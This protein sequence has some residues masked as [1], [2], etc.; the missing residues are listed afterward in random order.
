MSEIIIYNRIE[1]SILKS[2]YI[3]FGIFILA[4]CTDELSNQEQSNGET[5]APQG[6]V[7]I[8]VNFRTGSFHLPL[9]KS[10]ENLF[11]APWV[12]SFKLGNVD[13]ATPD[14]LFEEAVVLKQINKSYMMQLT[15]S[16]DAHLL[17]FVANASDLINK[18][19]ASFIG[20]KYW[21]VAS[22]LSFGDPSVGE[23]ENPLKNPQTTI[24]FISEPIPMTAFQQ[25]PKI[26]KGVTLSSPINLQRIV[27]KIYVDA[28]Q[29]NVASNFNLT[30]VTVVGVPAL[31]YLDNTISKE[32]VAPQS[33]VD[34]GTESIGTSIITG[35]ILNNIVAN[36][37]KSDSQDR[38]IYVYPFIK[39]ADN[40]GQF[41]VLL[42]GNFGGETKYFKIRLGGI[43]S[44][45]QLI[46]PNTSFIINIE[47][48][49][50]NGYVAIEHALR[51]E[52][53]TGVI[54]KVTIVD[55]AQSIIAN[56]K[57]FLGLTNTVCNLYADGS[58]DDFTVATVSTN[59]FDKGNIAP[60]SSIELINPV[61]MELIP[62]QMINSNSTDIKV[63]FGD[64]QSASGT[65]VVAI[66]DLKQHIQIKKDWA[67][68][69]NYKTGSTGFLLGDNFITAQVTE[70]GQ[71][72]LATTPNSADRLTSI[73]LPVVGSIYLFMNTGVG[74]EETELR[75]FTSDG[76]SVLVKN[77]TKIPEFAGS[78]IYWDLAHSRP[79][80][81]NYI[82]ARDKGTQ[83]IQG[84]MSYAWGSLIL[85]DGG[86]LN[87]YP[88]HL[89]APNGANRWTNLSWI[90]PGD[91]PDVAFND[92]VNGKIPLD[93]ANNTGDICEFMTRRGF[94]PS[95]ATGK[96][97]RLPSVKDYNALPR[98]YTKEGNWNDFETLSN[99]NGLSQ[100]SSF[101]NF[102]DL[103]YFT[104]TLTY[105][106]T[107]TTTR[108]GYNPE[109][110]Y[111]S[112]ERNATQYGEF[113]SNN[114]NSAEFRMADPSSNSVGLS[115]RCVR[116][117][118]PGVV[119][120]LFCI[121][122]D[123]NEAEGGIVTVPQ[124]KELLNQ[125][126][127]QGK[128]VTL[129]DITLI[130]DSGKRHIG[131]MI[132]GIEYALGAELPNIQKDETVVAKWI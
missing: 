120:P 105:I 118:S 68:V 85:G 57:Y 16:K 6:K 130:S 48:I 122:Y 79:A 116:D 128:S 10:T 42:E 103:F 65:I 97:W 23:G 56:G 127:D 25:I 87:P 27:S 53:S 78:N 69:G 11:D 117:D 15:A 47:S 1:M 19:Q 38:P 96:K 93:P 74:T 18:K 123:L 41:D 26:E 63:K 100:M 98:R 7:N 107:G 60:T 37:T 39:D 124:G 5:E 2:I 89:K 34:Y 13:S 125:F 55:N 72:G 3:L 110:M 112:T 51:H 4:S 131:W 90:K 92:L 9:T 40:G 75:L 71:A 64:E 28:S 82:E 81:D 61:N 59:A 50:S 126:A 106:T 108:L 24:P 17:M 115:L 45:N 52:P 43:G 73:D 36:T 44:S 54:V 129:S 132:D 12:L 35:L 21:E 99:N 32:S 88:G 86:T 121:S 70:G 62:G 102:S 113:Y 101:F 67:I 119:V 29:A 109:M 31:G 30:G 95:N 84:C 77:I 114:S 111:P 66:G 104:K 8:N 20:K 33:I 91:I 46:N 49:H 83:T 94:T 22:M 58:I 76:N 14:T 80:F